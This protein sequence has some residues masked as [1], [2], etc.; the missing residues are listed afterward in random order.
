MLRGG[1]GDCPSDFNL[2]ML[3]ETS[4]RAEGTH[5][6][7]NTTK[8]WVDI[9][10]NKRL[11]G[12]LGCLSVLTWRGKKNTLKEMPVIFGRSSS[13]RRHFPACIPDQTS[14]KGRLGMC[15]RR[16][17]ESTSQRVLSPCVVVAD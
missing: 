5:Q 7:A 4:Q 9:Y 16:R 13:S 11:V 2:I 17:L 8:P 12:L 10:N 15:S 14:G 1:T 6:R 3:L